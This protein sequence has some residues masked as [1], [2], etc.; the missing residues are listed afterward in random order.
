M[1]HNFYR[2]VLWQNAIQI[3]GALLPGVGRHCGAFGGLL[4]FWR[5][6]FGFVKEE[7]ELSHKLFC[8]LLGGHAKGLGDFCHLHRGVMLEHL[9]DGGTTLVGE[10]SGCCVGHICSIL[11]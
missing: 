10:S 1:L 4:L 9:H 2:N 11:G 5:P 8:S 6:R 3:A 7:A